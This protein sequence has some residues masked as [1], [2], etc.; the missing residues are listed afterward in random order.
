MAITVDAESFDMFWGT[1]SVRKALQEGESY[2]TIA[3][4]WE[5]ENE[6]FARKVPLYQLYQ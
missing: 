6:R 3:R 1:E 5:A 4:A 2:Q